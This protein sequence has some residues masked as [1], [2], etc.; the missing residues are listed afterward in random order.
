[1]ERKKWQTSHAFSRLPAARARIH[2]TRRWSA[3]P[4]TGR[5][6]AG[7]HVTL[8]DL[9]D[10]AMPLYD[11]DLEAAEGLPAAAQAF[12][13]LMLAHDGLLIA[14]PE[15][16]SSI[17]AVLKN[18]IDWVSRPVPDEPQLAAFQGKVAALMSAAAGGFGG[19]R[20]LT[21]VRA[22]L[23]NIGVLVLP[24]QVTLSQAMRAFQPDGSFQ[25]EAMQARVARLGARLATILQQLE[26]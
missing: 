9:R 2:S 16:N 7:A 1:M 13:Q 12:K 8:A 14:A 10:Y 18:T 26:T 20:S 21:H 6:S 4:R 17:S 19:V 25:D 11:G 3:L 22:I 23:G 5:A 15:Y 24:E